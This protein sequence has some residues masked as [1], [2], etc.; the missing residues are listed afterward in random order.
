MAV[1]LL[2]TNILIRHLVGDHPEQSPRATAFL[3]RVEAGEVTVRTTE[4][5]VFET[6]FTLERHYQQ[7]KARIREVLLPLLEL[8]GIL[9]PGKRR[10]RR[11][12]DRYVDL[13]LPF[14]DA[15]HAVLMEHLKLTEIISFD[16][17][18]DRVPGITRQEP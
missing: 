12:F 11:V 15:Y 1:A 6:V 10:L 18:F 2:D 13:N 16:R 7:S 14:A 17:H 4:L 8:P 5:V 9:L 3:H